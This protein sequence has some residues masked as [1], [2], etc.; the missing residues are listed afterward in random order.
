MEHLTSKL[1]RTVEQRSFCAEIVS[2]TQLGSSMKQTGCR[3]AE[4]HCNFLRLLNISLRV[5]TC[6]GVVCHLERIAF[7]P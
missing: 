7:K 5:S 1:D 6:P 2:L 4:T 3:P